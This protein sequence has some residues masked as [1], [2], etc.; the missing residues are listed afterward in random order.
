MELKEL[1]EKVEVFKTIKIIG[2]IVD[3]VPYTNDYLHE[4]VV[5]RNTSRAMYYLN[6]EK[7]LSEKEQ[8]KWYDNYL[9]KN[10]DIYWVI[11]NKKEEFI[12][13]TSLYDINYQQGSA[14]KG[15]LVVSKE[16]SLE[17]PYTLESELLLINI[18]FNNLDLKY[19]TTSV[20]A[21]NLEMQ[22]INKRLGFQFYR[23][24]IIR[25]EAYNQYRLLK[26]DFKS[27]YFDKIINHWR[28]RHERV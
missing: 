23:E 20:K 11:I 25:G 10:D 17:G 26:A 6:Q 24:V 5:L 14:E 16:K 27:E 15:R 2:S 12:G 21:D 22:S 9:K 1:M 8:R 28:K 19:I 7:E 13:T 3:L 4:V 18:A